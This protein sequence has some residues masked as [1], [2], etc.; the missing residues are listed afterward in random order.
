MQ[1]EERRTDLRKG[2][3]G[4]DVVDELDAP[5]QPREELGR[6][7]FEIVL[8]TQ[9]QRLRVRMEFADAHDSLG[10]RGALAGRGGTGDGE[11]VVVGRF[12][13]PALLRGKLEED[14][15]PKR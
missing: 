3:F 10:Q 5:S 11:A 9:H 15:L 6:I 8:R 2:E 1:G 12:D 7:R 13:G 14:Q 4:F